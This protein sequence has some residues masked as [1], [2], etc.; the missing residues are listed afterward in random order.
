MDVKLYTDEKY[1]PISEL[2]AFGDAFIQE[3]QNYRRMFLEVIQLGD[4]DFVNIVE[5][6]HLIK[7]RFIKN[8]ELKGLLDIKVENNDYILAIAKAI[9]QGESIGGIKIP[10]ADKLRDIYLANNKDLTIITNYLTEKIDEI[11]KVGSTDSLDKVFPELS[12]FEVKFIRKFNAKNLSYSISDFQ[13]QNK[14]SYETA[15]KALDKLT[16]LKL[17][18]KQKVGKKFVYMPTD[19]LITVVKGGE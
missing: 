7:K 13:E 10:Q 9:A 19:K 11:I 14:T 3:T 17:Y 2:K 4:L 1:V 16:E 12:K 5:T 8:I 15:R 6:P 18:I